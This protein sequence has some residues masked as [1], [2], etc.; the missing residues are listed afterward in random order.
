MPDLCNEL[1][2]ISKPDKV[3]GLIQICGDVTFRDIGIYERIEHHGTA[4]ENVQEG[5]GV[6]P[7]DV[8]D[9][10]IVAQDSV[11]TS[12]EKTRGDTHRLQYIILPLKS[13]CSR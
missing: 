2:V 11:S 8:K 12:K 1:A 7:S 5:K 10:R 3:Q 13:C 6:N 4:P 9:F